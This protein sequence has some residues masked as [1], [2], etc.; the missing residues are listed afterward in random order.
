MMVTILMFLLFVCVCGLLVIFSKN[1]T[2]QPKRH[3]KITK[4]IPNPPKALTVIPGP[5]ASQAQP[6]AW[7]KVRPCLP[8]S[9]RHKLEVLTEREGHQQTMQLG[10]KALV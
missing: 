5:E 7:Q 4:S 8:S 10:V 1:A 6:L 9:V 3:K 2:E